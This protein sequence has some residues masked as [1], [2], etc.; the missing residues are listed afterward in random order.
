MK[1]FGSKSGFTLV[2]LIVVI[3]ILG[4]LAAVAVPAYTGYIDKARE[5]A[6]MQLLSS[7]ATAAQGLNATNDG[8]IETIT[9]AADGTVTVTVES[10]TAPTDAEIEE[11]TGELTYS[12]NFKGAKVDYTQPNPAWEMD[13][14]T[15]TP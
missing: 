6:D 11:L 9:V 12:A 5:A 13:D 15:T 1:K 10:G 2:E 14:A 3:A 8:E 4:I 7:V